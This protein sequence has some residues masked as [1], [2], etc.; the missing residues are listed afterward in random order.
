M[1]V[2]S[3][4]TAGSNAWNNL[5]HAVVAGRTDDGGPA[6]CSQCS[7]E[8]VE[9][10]ALA[11]LDV[12]SL[13]LG[14]TFGLAVA[15]ETFGDT[16]RS[17][18][19]PGRLFAWGDNY[20][21]QLGTGDY[22]ARAAP[23]LVR[24]CCRTARSVR[25]RRRCTRTLDEERLVAVR[26]GSFHALAVTDA[27]ALYAW[28]WNAFGQLGVGILN[29]N[30]TVNAPVAVEHLETAGLR[31]VDASGGYAHSLVLV[32]SGQVFAMGANSK[33]QLGVGSREMSRVPVRVQVAGPG[34]AP[35]SFKQVAAG[36]FHSLAVT[37]DG[38]VFAWGSNRY[39]QL[40]LC[41][42]AP[43]TSGPRGICF[44]DSADDSGFFDHLAPAPVTE[45]AGVRIASISAG[46][47]HTIAV[48]DAGDVYAWGDNTRRQLGVPLALDSAG[49]A[50]LY[51]VTPQL[52]RRLHTPATACS[53]AA[54]AVGQ[55]AESEEA[56]LFSGQ[57]V[58]RCHS[59]DE[60]DTYGALGAVA[61]AGDAHTI[62]VVH[63]RRLHCST[64]STPR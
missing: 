54:A 59:D 16:P 21:G 29:M 42:A 17:T 60:M 20:L 50:V 47:R 23:T 6:P 46:A 7:T 32:S 12:E 52:V 62:V 25:G 39:G 26:A 58:V 1:G 61:V 63:Q 55:P 2:R 24:S 33:G 36:L 3:A 34:G 31:V 37:T 22:A 4:Y 28:G 44:V 10:A 64:G 30:P 18:P 13:A 27:G 48:S 45:L 57:E 38:L 14:R 56:M 9:V 49:N 15:S 43:R 41:A 53:H 40:G 8:A 11:A 19:Q 5:G 35:R 51:H